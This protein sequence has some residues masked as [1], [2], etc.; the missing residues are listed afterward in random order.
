MIFDDHDVHD[1]WNISEAWVATCA[2][3]PWWEERISGAF[4]AYWV[5][6]HIGNLAPPELADEPL[7]GRVQADED[8]GPRLRR[9]R[10]PRTASR[11]RA[12]SPSTATSAARGWS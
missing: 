7:L 4:M 9:S 11:P 2:R 8:G 10:A 5:Y 1:D 6:Q 3:Q 12:A